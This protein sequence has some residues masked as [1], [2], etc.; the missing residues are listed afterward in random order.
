MKRTIIHKFLATAFCLGTVLIAAA[1]DT[2]N[3]AAVTDGGNWI[4]WGLLSLVVFIIFFFVMVFGRL[5]GIDGRPAERPI[6]FRQ[7]WSLLDRKL[8]TRAVAVEK[9]QDV[10][11]DHDYD[12]IRELDNALPPWW[13][14][15]FYITLVLAVIYMLRFHVWH[16]G[17]TPEQEYEREMQVAAA[18]V[19]AYRQKS[20]EMVDEKTVTM[21]DAAGIAEGK[22]IYQTNCFACHGMNGEGGVGPN[23]TDAYWI[24]GGTINDVFKTI[25]YGVPDKGMQAWEKTYSPTQMKNLASYIRSIVGSNPANGKAPQGDLFTEQ[26]SDSTKAKADSTAMVKK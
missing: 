12:G 1:Q 16:T 22:K 9:E 5:K 23:L 2:G 18:Q 14:Y 17:P 26:P 25:K 24:H 15:G 8:F 13:K 4:Y 7:W 3:T 19:E 6:S 21:A 10:L 11:L 20:G